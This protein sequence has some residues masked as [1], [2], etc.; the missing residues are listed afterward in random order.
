[1]N[2]LLVRV[3]SIAL[4]VRSWVEAAATAAGESEYTVLNGWCAI[5]SCELHKRL[6]KSGIGQ[7]ELHLAQDGSSCH[8][9]VMV[10]DHIVDVTATQFRE[11]RYDAVV[12]CHHREIEHH[13]YYTTSKIFTSGKDLRK[14][15]LRTGW[16]SS[17]IAY[18]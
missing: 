11:F 16:P 1:M 12:I 2:A 7:A 18:G 14:D 8:I 5:A 17:Q 15:Q 9:F 3:H 10:D 13:W 6:V 4:E